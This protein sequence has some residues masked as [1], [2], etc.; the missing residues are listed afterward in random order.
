MQ[1]YDQIIS[2]LHYRLGRH[3]FVCTE[4]QVRHA[5]RML[6]LQLRQEQLTVALLIYWLLR[7]GGRDKLPTDFIDQ[8][9]EAE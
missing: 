1:Y 6:A 4:Q 5:V 9:A 7:E 2:S 8:L 3:Q